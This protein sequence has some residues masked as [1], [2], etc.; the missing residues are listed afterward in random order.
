MTSWYK[1]D[2]NIDIRVVNLSNFLKDLE[3]EL[4]LKATGS[5]ITIGVEER[6]YF[7]PQRIRKTFLPNRTIMGT[8][9]RTTTSTSQIA[10]GHEFGNSWQ[11]RRS[12]LETT[13]RRFVKQ[14]MKD[15]VS[16]DYKY[17]G[18]F[19]KALTV[20][21]YDMI[22]ECFTTSGWGS[23]KALS[24]KYKKITGRTDPPLIDTGQ[25][26]SAVYAQYEGFTVKGRNIGGFIHG[27]GGFLNTLYEFDDKPLAID[28]RMSSKYRKESLSKIVKPKKVQLPH[29]M[30]EKINATKEIV[31]TISKYKQKVEQV[32]FEYNGRKFK[33]K[34]AM[35]L[36][37]QAI[38][39]FRR[40]KQ[41]EADRELNELIQAAS[42]GRVR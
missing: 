12:F 2:P 4:N 13:A 1:K 36:Y 29:K 20:K 22:V 27:A 30:V 14:S 11:P 7:T 8:S 16:K 38:I 35:E 37:K 3:R 19:L 6:P 25:L 15:I 28:K 33:T 42:E 26:L 10:A 40:R 17:I 39:G 34:Q 32:S 31:S 5:F 9:F 41:Q 23:W 24:E 18:S 21:L